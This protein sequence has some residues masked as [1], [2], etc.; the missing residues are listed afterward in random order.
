MLQLDK[1]GNYRLQVKEHMS[2]LHSFLRKREHGLCCEIFDALDIEKQVRKELEA[3]TIQVADAKQWVDKACKQTWWRGIVYLR[4]GLLKL[5]YRPVSP[6][7]F[8]SLEVGI[9]CFAS[10]SFHE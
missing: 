6:V 2:E 10:T 5:R 3:I 1:L 8:V 4:E 7:C 9:I